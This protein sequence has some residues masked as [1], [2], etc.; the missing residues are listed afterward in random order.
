MLEEFITNRARDGARGVAEA[1]FPENDYGAPD[2]R[3]TDLVRRLFDYMGELPPRQRRLLVTLFVFI[4][5]LAPFLVPGLGRFSKLPIARRER[6]VRRF[7]RSRLFLLRVLGDALKAT[8][9]LIY[10]SHPAALA[11]VG[12]YSGCARPEDPLPVEVRRA[13]PADR[14]GAQSS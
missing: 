14:T 9:T 13:Q 6:A 11:Y 4:E 10:M 3:T 1:L 12:M 2:F 5:L 8:T 7:R